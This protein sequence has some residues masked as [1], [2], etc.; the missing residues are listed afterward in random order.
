[1]LTPAYT[2]SSCSYGEALPFILSIPLFTVR[3]VPRIFVTDNPKLGT[4]IHIRN[5]N[6]SIYFFDYP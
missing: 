2:D 4:L 1:M 6:M 5:L 3:H